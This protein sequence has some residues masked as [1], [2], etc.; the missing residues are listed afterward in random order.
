MSDKQEASKKP[1]QKQPR[2]STPTTPQAEVKQ[3]SPQSVLPS[4]LLL[5][6]LESSPKTIS[7]EQVLQL[8]RL[9]GNRATGQLLGREEQP[10]K[11]LK[12][13][14]PKTAIQP[15]LKVGPANDKYEQ[16]ADR[17]A[18]QVMRLPTQTD[19]PQQKPIDT[20]Q[21]QAEEDEL[22]MKPIETIQRDGGGAGFTVNNQ[23]Q[24]E[25][26]RSGS[27]QP[28]PNDIQADFGSKMG[29]DFSGVRVHTDSQAAD[30]NRQIQAKAF[31]HK[32]H[33]YMGAGQY[34]PNTVQGKRL[35]AHETTHT[36]QQRAIPINKD[37][38]NQPS[39]K[40]VDS[41]V[42]RVTEMEADDWDRETAAEFM[43][44]KQ[45]KENN[46]QQEADLANQN[47]AN[48]SIWYN[49]IFSPGLKGTNYDEAQE[50]VL[51]QQQ[52]MLKR[53]FLAQ[54]VF[55]VQGGTQYKKK[56][57]KLKFGI[58]G[59]KH[60]KKKKRFFRVVAP[61]KAE[62]YKPI[63]KFQKD[64]VSANLATLASGGGRFNYRSKD[65]TG[66]P[67]NQFLMFGNS[68][69]QRNL[70]NVRGKR[71]GN[72]M[73]TNYM[74]AYKR[75]GTHGEA[76]TNGHIREI[77]KK[78]GGIDAT[79]FDIPIGGVGLNLRDTKQRNVTTGY[80]GTSKANTTGRLR[81]ALNYVRKLFR[82]SPTYD[83]KNYQTGHGFHR[84]KT[85]KDGKLGLTQIAFEGSGPR[86]DNIHGGSHG[87]MATIGKKLF[88][89]SSNKT[90][91]GQDKRS[92]LGLPRK[93]GGIKADV[94]KDGLE[95][96]EKYYEAVKKL[97]NSN[98][99]ED[100][101]KVQNFYKKLLT[102]TTQIER[103]KILQEL[104]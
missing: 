7:P 101:K 92:K 78:F 53:H 84:H 14:M 41:T 103:E 71:N 74:G 20:V 66:N 42:Q 50:K 102:S 70:N 2:L 86:K 81:R 104:E 18:D 77:N 83:Y 25:L 80:Q 31:T 22:Q 75:I 55:G 4:S 62:E 3:P 36:I 44:T 30:L 57:K 63:E 27:G 72:Q 52:A 47:K 76:F 15:K 67:F 35:L 38:A 48:A 61:E 13:F 33:I 16:E 91:T 34:N 59:G 49:T 60:K 65:G 56:K 23:F 58:Q 1:V 100:Q 21:R 94:T 40:N 28:L 37:R 64:G 43:M 89:H 45:V 96:L 73:P 29:A 69:D 19:A 68:K 82:R 9:V 79:G 97:S 24:D 46:G 32:N 11:P 85:T 39:L 17:M 51:K 88:G 98:K 8:Q 54:A 10:M 87:I 26:K 6:R 93:V 90:L 99:K 95:R 5:Q 12:P